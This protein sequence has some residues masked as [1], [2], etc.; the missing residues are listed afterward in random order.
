VKVDFKSLMKTGRAV[1][2]KGPLIRVHYANAVSG[3]YKF[4]VNF[5]TKPAA[6]AAAKVLVKALRKAK[7]NDEYNA[8]IQVWLS[9]LTELVIPG[10]RNDDGG[11]GQ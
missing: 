3:T 1:K 5:V 2:V 6:E 4:D 11:N 9:L 10:Q 7:S 8:T